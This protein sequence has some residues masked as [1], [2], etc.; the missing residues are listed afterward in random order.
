[1]PFFFDEFIAP[2]CILLCTGSK[3]LLQLHTYVYPWRNI[4]PKLPQ[5]SSSPPLSCASL[6]TGGFRVSDKL[7]LRVQVVMGKKERYEKRA[8][9]HHYAIQK[10]QRNWVLCTSLW[11]FVVTFMPLFSIN[12]CIFV[13]VHVY[14]S[15]LHNFYFEFYIYVLYSLLL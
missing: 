13:F 15:L 3:F 7:P 14:L 2:Y 5:M 10:Q 6:L 11:S 1:M 4:K 12:W 9:F 8:T